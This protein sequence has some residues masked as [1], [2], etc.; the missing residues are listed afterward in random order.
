MAPVLSSIKSL[1]LKFNDCLDVPKVK[2]LYDRT[3]AIKKRISTIILTEFKKQLPIPSTEISYDTYSNMCKI[4]DELSYTVKQELITY[5]TDQLL[6]PYD[7]LFALGQENALLIDTD[8]RYAWCRRQ[9]KNISQDLK[10]LFP[11]QWN[12]EAIL[13]LVSN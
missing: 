2:I 9:I 12:I 3:L 7:K 1:F 10:L 5:L 11:D 6:I 8:R 13:Y 4:I